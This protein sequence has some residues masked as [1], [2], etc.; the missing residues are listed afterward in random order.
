MLNLKAMI[1]FLLFVLIFA[2]THYTTSAQQLS[3]TESTEPF[4]FKVYPNPAKIGKPIIINFTNPQVKEASII[5][6]NDAGQL[7]FL[8]KIAFTTGHDRSISIQTKGLPAGLYLL[9][10]SASGKMHQQTIIL[11]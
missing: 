11:R 4:I 2:G 8:R 5:I 1:I 3:K 6:S 7:V 10:G 9:M